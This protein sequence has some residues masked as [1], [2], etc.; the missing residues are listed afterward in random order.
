V[1]KG[2]QGLWPDYKR[3]M[4]NLSRGG[5]DAVVVREFD[6]TTKSFVDGGFSLP[7]AKSDV[8]WRDENS[9]WI[10]TDFGEGSLTTSGYPRFA[11]LWKR[12]TP[13]ESATMVHEVPAEFVG[14]GAYSIHTP[15]GR[16]DL[17]T[18][19]PEFFRGT[20]YIF[21]NDKL[22]KLEIPEDA[23]L[24]KIFKQQMLV[25][26]RSDWNV[27]GKTYP[28]DALLAIGL[29]DFLSGGRNFSVLFEPKER[30]ALGSTWLSPHSTMCAAAS[31]NTR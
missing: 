30:V 9:L 2:A 16:Y 11:K 20:T 27:G 14:L 13:V 21:R 25:S 5:G 15:E 4:V 22:V 12:G 24:Q 18:E 8:A 28:Q 23:E 6:A 7:E 3:F 17:V 26:L 1:W 10:G 31:T 29:D 19:T